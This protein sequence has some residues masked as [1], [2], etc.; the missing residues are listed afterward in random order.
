[1]TD[2]LSEGAQNLLL[3]CA[4]ARTGESL[5][6]ICEDH[7]LGWYDKE[8]A[9]AIDNV[10]THLGLKVTRLSVKGPDNE[11]LTHTADVIAGY[12]LTVFLSRIG[13]QNRFSEKATGTRTVMCY[14]REARQLASAYGR[15]HH[16]A[17]SGLKTAVDSL[18]LNSSNI[19]ITCPLG[20][21]ISGKVSLS[22]R[23]GSQD[24]SVKRFPLGVPKPILCNKLNGYVALAHYL[25]PTGSKVY[26]PASIAINSTV[27][28]EINDGHLVK[29]IGDPGDVMRIREHYNH[30]A[31]LFN[32]DGNAVHS[33]HAG[34]HPATTYNHLASDDPDRWSNSV[35][36]NPRFLHFHTCGAYAPGEIC[37][38]VLDPTVSID[39]VNLW[40]AGQLKV[41]RFARTRNCLNKWPELI[42]LFDNPSNEIGL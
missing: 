3:N 32:I 19:R 7:S 33:F 31:G 41:K 18:L 16:H 26:E 21:N 4:Q 34:I 22:K 12:D 17:L 1:M 25:T 35:F 20:T 5:L 27:L 24:V 30:V 28:A 36:T 29:F 8:I 11:D 9:S 15:T 42:P 39:D 13:D 2:F 14:A 38:M 37:W 40:E 23:D 10:A 6:L